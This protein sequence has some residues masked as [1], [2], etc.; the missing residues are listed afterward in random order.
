MIGNLGRRG[1]G[2]TGRRRPPDDPDAWL[3]RVASNVVRG[4]WRHAKVV[5][6]AFPRLAGGQQPAT[7]PAEGVDDRMALLAALRQ[8]PAEQRETLAWHYFADLPIAVVAERME[9][10]VGTVEAPPVARPGHP[11]GH[12][13]PRPFSRERPS[14]R[15]PAFGPDP[16]MRQPAFTAIQARQARR[17]RR[18]V[19]AGGCLSQSSSLARCGRAAGCH[20]RSRSHR[21]RLRLLPRHRRHR[22]HRTHRRVRVRATRA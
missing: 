1:L 13:F 20:R 17:V 7:A 21:P 10:T 12:C 6:R 15:T 9:V 5:Q 14:A 3:Y 16:G 8:L 19:A 11:W 4:R 2:M 18:R 22:P